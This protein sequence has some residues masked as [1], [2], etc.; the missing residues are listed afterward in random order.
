MLYHSSGFYFFCV[1]YAVEDAFQNRVI[2][3]RYYLDVEWPGHQYRNH[4]QSNLQL[5]AT[6][7]VF[8]FAKPRER[9]LSLEIFE[10]EK[11]RWRKCIGD[12]LET[13]QLVYCFGDKGFLWGEEKRM[14]PI[15]S[16][17]YDLSHLYRIYVCTWRKCVERQR[18]SLCGRS[19][20]DG[21][22]GPFGSRMYAECTIQI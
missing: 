19:F 13:D 9:G 16:F 6:V 20:F 4:L 2:Y 8:V 3:G 1:I 18:L 10:R 22:K 12:G 11:S 21:V 14:I 5:F 15:V 7:Q 17:L